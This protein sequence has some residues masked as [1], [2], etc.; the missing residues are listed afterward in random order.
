MVSSKKID[1]LA[2][3]E[4]WLKPSDTLSCL[5]DLTPLGFSLLHKPR[6]HGRGDGVGFLISNEFK[7]TD[8]T[9]PS[10]STFECICLKVSGSSFE[11]LVLC[12][13]HPEPS[14]SDTFYQEF[15]ELLELLI[16]LATEFYILGDFNLHLDK[17]QSLTTTKFCGIL[18]SF[19]LE[20]HENF[21]THI[22][23]H[24]LD[25]LITRTSCPAVRSVLACDG[26]SDHFLVLLELEFP[27]PK[28]VK[29]KIPFRRINEIDLD[30][31]KNDILNSDL[32]TKP[33]KELPKLCKQYDT[34]LQTILNKHAPLLTKTVS[35]RPPTPWMTQ[36][37]L[38]AKVRRRRL[39]RAWRRTRYRHDR[40]RYR[41]QCNLC[42]RIMEKAKSNFN[43][44]VILE[45]SEDPKKLRISI[46]NI[47]HRF[48]A[49]SLPENLSL[50]T[51]CEKFSNFF[52]DKITIIR[53]KFPDD[54]ETCIPCTT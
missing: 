7:V 38:K 3:T 29:K 22:H 16:P 53:S 20:Q 19:D 49:P 14:H 27:R 23:G 15:Q 24:W 21:P 31:L 9:I 39:K 28:C 11:G 6:T 48:P 13:Y 5:S 43:A 54:N 47:L 10:F 41:V 26:L 30:N 36:E 50:K 37:I 40:S 2:I 51:I 8:Y 34:I 25:L 44:K 32:K 12:M 35:E 42:N 33:E 1:I 45:N 18:E 46:N 52:V 17:K 4:T